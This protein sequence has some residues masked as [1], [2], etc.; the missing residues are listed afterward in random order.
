MVSKL[1][2]VSFLI[3]GIFFYA[4]FGRV[5]SLE[6][7]KTDTHNREFNTCFFV[8]ISHETSLFGRF[9][10][11]Y[12]LKILYLCAFSHIYA[13]IHMFRIEL[14]SLNIP[15]DNGVHGNNGHWKYVVDEF[16]IG[17]LLL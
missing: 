2:K 14:F 6:F 11:F 13:R 12:T 16:I 15:S 3:L 10:R 7:Y 5:F 17:L 9:I 4:K 1:F 8:V